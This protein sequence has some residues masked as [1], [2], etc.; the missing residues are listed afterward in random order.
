M[1]LGCTCHDPKLIDLQIKILIK[2]IATDAKKFAVSSPT[3]NGEEDLQGQP[4]EWLD[5]APR[6]ESF[7]VFL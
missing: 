6:A 4:V 7:R 5:A 2:F 3:A 1:Q